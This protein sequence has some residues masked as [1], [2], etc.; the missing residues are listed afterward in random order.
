MA[1]IIRGGNMGKFNTGNKFFLWVCVIV[2][3][4]GLIGVLLISLISLTA[5]APSELQLTQKIAAEFSCGIGDVQY[6]CTGYDVTPQLLDT[7][8]VMKRNFVVFLDKAEMRPVWDK[9]IRVDLDN[10]KSNTNS[11]VLENKTKK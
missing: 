4:A 8:I 10:N 11:K 3:T 1:G 5:T 7:S 9:V 6:F 2:V